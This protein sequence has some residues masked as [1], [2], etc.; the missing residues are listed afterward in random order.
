MGPTPATHH[1]THET[2]GMDE[3]DVGGLHGVLADVQ[4]VAAHAADHEFGGPDPIPIETLGT[5]ETDDTLGLAP[6]APATSYSAPKL[7]QS[8]RSQTYQQRRWTTPSSLLRTVLAASNS[9]P[10]Q[11]V[12]TLP[13]HP[14]P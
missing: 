7:Q 13:P 11:A 12:P 1:T 6:E 10:K 2:G 5:A 8:P 4:P 9:A 3:L 14:K